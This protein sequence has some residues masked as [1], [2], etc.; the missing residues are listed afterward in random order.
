MNAL[1][2]ARQPA[3]RRFA[4]ATLTHDA[5]PAASAPSSRAP[6]NLS[7]VEAQWEK[8]DSSERAALHEQ[9]EAIT[10]KDWKELSIDEKKAAYYVSFGPHGPRAPVSKPGD[11]L[12]AFLGFAALIGVSATV[13]FGIRSIGGEPPK[14]ITKEWQEA[15]NEIAI[16]Q[17]ANPISGIT[18]EGYKGE[19]FV[20]A[21]K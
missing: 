15:S 2:L 16:K 18:S 11:N 12:K 3:V 8:F 9:L 4:T 14:T 1:R 10:K 6:I 7:N 19:G 5:A 13:F 20:Q 21:K 17:K